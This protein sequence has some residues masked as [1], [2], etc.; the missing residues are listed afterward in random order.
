MGIFDAASL[1]SGPTSQNITNSSIAGWAQPYINNYLTGAQNL[2]SQG[3]QPNALMQQSY[4]AAAGLKTPDQFGQGSSLL[5][6]AGQG[7][8]STTGQALNYGQQGS[9][10]GGLGLAYGMGAGQNYQNMATNPAAVG[11]YM[12]PYVQQSLAPTLGLLNQQQQLEQQKA[13]GQATGQGA[14]G[15]NRAAL[16]QGL[17]GQNYDLAK[18]QAIAQGYNTAF[19]N[20]QQAQQFGANLG[21]QGAMQGTSAGLQGT[22]LGLQGVQGAQQGYQ[23][24][25]QAGVGL[26]NL[27][28]QQ[29]QAD[30]SRIG[31]QNQLGLQQYQLPYQNLQFMQ[32][33]MQ[34]LP[35]SNQTTQGY[36]A[37][38]NAL[39]QMAG[40]GTTLLGGYGLL[41]KTGLLPS[42][43]GGNTITSAVSNSPDNSYQYS[44]SMNTPT[45]TGQTSQADI[46][47][48]AQQAGYT[49]YDPTQNAKGGAIKEKHYASGGLVSLAL[50]K[51]LKG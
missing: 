47:N 51:A 8:L 2:T 28:Y 21:L 11:A 34:G 14:F 9:G 50:A 49:S 23:G 44:G 7:Q 33:I 37:P 35:Y 40:I 29:N 4:D 38:P 5:N 25:S 39:S 15:G 10:I 1:P 20:A 46:V 16:Q 3:G 41:N 45:S 31:L 18:Q 22:S 19:Q 26:G 36:Q 42:L 27:G 6:Q 13:Q 32:G 24:A 30:V 43:G 48:A 17:I 12:N